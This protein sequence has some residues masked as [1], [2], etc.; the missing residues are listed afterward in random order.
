MSDQGDHLI[1]LSA[2]NNSGL[3][4]IIQQLSPFVGDES[5][6]IAI[7]FFT[8]LLAK[9]G[10]SL[11][12]MFPILFPSGIDQVAGIDAD[13]LKVDG[14]IR[15]LCYGHRNFFIQHRIGLINLLDLENAENTDH[16]GD[17]GKHDETA[18][19]FCCKLHVLKH[20]PYLLLLLCE[21][22]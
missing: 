4:K 3:F 8:D 12:K 22:V 2:V 20:T 10:D 21:I 13:P 14:N 11:F 5:F 17:Q 9:I 1:E 19:D 7:R 16:R 18:D 6:F 15:Q